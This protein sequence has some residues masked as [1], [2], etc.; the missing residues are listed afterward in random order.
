VKA[1]RAKLENA[2]SS[3][4]KGLTNGK[5]MLDAGGEAVLEWMQ[6][7]ND[8]AQTR[9]AM[10]QSAFE[11]KPI[12]KPNLT[13]A[14]AAEV[15]KIEDLLGSDMLRAIYVK[16]WQDDIQGGKDVMTKSVFVSKRLGKVVALK[17]GKKLK[18]LR[19]LLLLIEWKGLLLPGRGG[20]K[21]LAKP[22][23]I[24]KQMGQIEAG[25]IDKIKQRFAPD[26]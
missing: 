23:A 8:P 13:A 5:A 10:Q 26:G 19:Y 1:L 3:P 21:R 7:T 25:V 11:A 9:E 16:G 18:A 2:I 15:Y 22:E 12:P 24:R 6:L 17:D 14:T 4:V 20:G